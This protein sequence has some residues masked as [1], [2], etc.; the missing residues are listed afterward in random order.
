MIFMKD[1]L[2]IFKCNYM[3]FFTSSHDR[4]WFAEA[5]SDISFCANAITDTVKRK[6]K[7]WLLPVNLTLFLLGLFLVIADDYIQMHTLSV[8]VHMICIAAVCFFMILKFDAWRISDNKN[9]LKLMYIF[10]MSVSGGYASLTYI[11]LIIYENI[12]AYG[13]WGGI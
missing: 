7:G 12:V 1:L 13:S 10:C 8:F 3:R 5:S 6:G 11:F 4:E 9:I 2:Y